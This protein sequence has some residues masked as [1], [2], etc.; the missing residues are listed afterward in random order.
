MM[1]KQFPP[2]PWSDWNTMPLIHRKH[3]EQ[4]MVT[5]AQTD[6]TF[7]ELVYVSV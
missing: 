3:C 2:L 4:G 7:L 1:S 5:R 6:V